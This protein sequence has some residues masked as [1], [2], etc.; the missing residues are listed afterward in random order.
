MGTEA[1][2]DTDTGNDKTLN[3]QLQGRSSLEGMETEGRD[4]EAVMQ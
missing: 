2:T 3:I 4:N 1:D